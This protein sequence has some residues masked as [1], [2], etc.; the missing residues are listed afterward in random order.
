MKSLTGVIVGAV[1]VITVIGG[2]IWYQ[3][4]QKSKTTGTLFIGITDA[5]ADIAQVNEIDLTVKQVEIHSTTRGWVSVSSDTKSYELLALHAAEKTKV[6]AKENVAAETYDK[7][8][9]TLGEATIKTKARG[10]LKAT[11]PSSYV[12]INTNVIVKP[13]TD[14]HLKLDVLADQSLHETSDGAYVFAPVIKAES[15]NSAEISEASDNS[16]TVSGGHIDSII[17]AGVDLDGTS[18]TNFVLKT[19]NTLKVQSSVQGAVK[20]LLGGKLYEESDVAGEAGA[21]ATGNS[22]SGANINAEI[23]A[24]NASTSGS[25]SVDLNLDL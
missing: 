19:D 13:G 21:E 18:K 8:R 4:N 10:D 22:N 3:N 14:S 17:T 7:V 23:N 5:T 16:L 6:Y 25:G 20:I 11:L 9:V 24:S 1:L 2:V 15:R 12:V